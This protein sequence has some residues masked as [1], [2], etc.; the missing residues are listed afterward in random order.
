[1]GQGGE[2]EGGKTTKKK[3]RD[4]D[5][6]REMAVFAKIPHSSKN[7]GIIKRTH[8]F[9]AALSRS[10]GGMGA[11]GERERDGGSDRESSLKFEGLSLSWSSTAAGAAHAVELMARCAGDELLTIGCAAFSASFLLSFSRTSSPSI[12]VK[13]LTLSVNGLSSL[14]EREE[15]R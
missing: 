7:S 9:N 4:S 6:R 13:R 2:P 5:R 15:R 11:A 10:L 1:M 12:S 14:G 8:P 3:K